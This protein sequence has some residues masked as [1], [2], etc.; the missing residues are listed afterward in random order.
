MYTSCVRV[1]DEILLL[2]SSSR[3]ISQNV[4]A[5]VAEIRHDSN[6]LGISGISGDET[7]F[8]YIVILRVF[9]CRGNVKFIYPPRYYSEA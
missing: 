1:M 6:I 7:G 5:S 4:F 3:R 2:P 8:L 9:S